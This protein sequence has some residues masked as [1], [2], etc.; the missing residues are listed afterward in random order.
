VL[1][2]GEAGPRI[3]QALDGHV[4]VELLHSGFDEVMETAAQRAVPGTTVLLSPACSSFDMFASYEER[5][6]RFTTLAQAISEDVE[7]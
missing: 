3:F 1:T 5:G 2:F 4:P 7:H 6:S